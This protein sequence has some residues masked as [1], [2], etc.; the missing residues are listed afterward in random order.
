MAS[1][2][3]PLTHPPPDGLLPTPTL[4]TPSHPPPQN[5]DSQ[6]LQLQQTPMMP[7]QSD[8]LNY[9]ASLAAAAQDPLLMQQLNQQMQFMWYQQQEVG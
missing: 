5:V 9:N 6:L 8:I 1:L 3:T 7:V 2:T 4:H